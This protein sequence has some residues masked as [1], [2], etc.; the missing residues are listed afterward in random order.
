MDQMIE[1]KD[2]E[3]TIRLNA[4][5]IGCTLAEA[6][7]IISIELGETHGDMIAL[8]DDGNEIVPPPSED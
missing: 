7:E 3:E 2:R 8:D 6:E 4:E 5:A 1:G